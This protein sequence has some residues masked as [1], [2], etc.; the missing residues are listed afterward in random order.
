MSTLFPF[1]GKE[2]VEEHFRPLGSGPRPTGGLSIG[3]TAQPSAGNCWADTGDTCTHTPAYDLGLSS[4][5]LGSWSSS[6]ALTVFLGYSLSSS[7]LLFLSNRS[8]EAH[9]HYGE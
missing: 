7:G 3:S 8:D 1:S 9:L 6:L 4:S 2:S 5:K